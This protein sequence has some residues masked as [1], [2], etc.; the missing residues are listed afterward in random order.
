MLIEYEEVVGWLVMICEVVEEKW[1]L[2]WFVDFEYGDFFNDGSFIM[3]EWSLI[4]SWIDY[5]CLFGD[6]LCVL[7][8]LLLDLDWWIFILD[9]IFVIVDWFV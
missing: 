7:E 2:L 3:L 5:G 4:K 9:K 1:M 6:L 8:L